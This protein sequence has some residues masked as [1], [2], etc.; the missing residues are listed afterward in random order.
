MLLTY[1]LCIVY[2]GDGAREEIEIRGEAV[3]GEKRGER[4]KRQR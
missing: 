2:N 3:V 4:R 1:D